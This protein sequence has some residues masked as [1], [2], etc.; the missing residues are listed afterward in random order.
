M[1]NGKLYVVSMYDHSLFAHRGIEA[2][3]LTLCV[4]R[5]ATLLANLYSANSLNGGAT[6]SPH[7]RGDFQ[8][9]AVVLTSIPLHRHVEVAGLCSDRVVRLVFLYV[10][11][12]A[13]RFALGRGGAFRG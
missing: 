5:L 7:F 8:K 6:R 13:W 12:V 10:D 3:S 4:G 1:G 9:A 2:F 11:S